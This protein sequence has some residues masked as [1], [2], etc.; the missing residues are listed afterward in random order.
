MRTVA[1]PPDRP[2]ANRS[3][4][5]SLQPRHDLPCR[6]TALGANRSGTY[7]HPGRVLLQ[8]RHDLPGRS[9]AGSPDRSVRTGL[10][11]IRTR[12]GCSYN[13]GT[14]S[15]VGAP[16]SV[17][18]GIARIRMRSGCSYNHGTTSPCRSTALGAN[19]AAPESA[20]QPQARRTV[21]SNPAASTNMAAKLRLTRRCWRGES[22]SRMT[23]EANPV[24]PAMTIRSTITMVSAITRY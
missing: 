21:A 12:R 16:P 1:A 10:A 6:S 9:T 20:A 4:T 8:P 2:G 13:Y 5:H 23:R 3:S 19:S 24:Y 7:S 18:T 22:S 14:T 11:R 17:R 15:P